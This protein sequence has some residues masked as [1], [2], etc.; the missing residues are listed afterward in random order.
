MTQ[1][2][3]DLQADLFARLA[4]RDYLKLAPEQLLWRK[5]D[6]APIVGARSLRL[7]PQVVAAPVRWREAVKEFA[8][9]KIPA[10]RFA[11]MHGLLGENVTMDVSYFDEARVNFRGFLALGRRS[12][13][14]L[15]ST[16]LREHPPPVAV[17]VEILA[18]G[19][20]VEMV[21]VPRDLLSGMWLIAIRASLHNIKPVR[22][23]AYIGCDNPLTGTARNAFCC[24]YHRA[25]AAKND[26]AKD[27]RR[28]RELL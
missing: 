17:N 15:A 13:I 19:G 20:Q 14:T 3:T 1:N 25:A 18:S 2:I 7:P 22:I 27:K 26:H 21:L 28:L 6:R 10:K 4:S 5:P 12:P 8:D 24:D 11:E 9:E 23:C 16:Y